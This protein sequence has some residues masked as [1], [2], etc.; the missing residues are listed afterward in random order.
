MTTQLA[1]P[2]PLR[3]LRWLLASSLAANALAAPNAS[4][5]K[6]LFS[7]C[8]VCHATAT[9]EKKVGPS[10]KGLF[11]HAKLKNG[12]SVSVPNVLKMIDTGGNGMPSYADIL[13]PQDKQDVIAYLR[14]L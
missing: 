1:S 14:T 7:Q 8:Q 4:N 10:L 11:K 5:G 13:S 12:R 6:A 3:P 2:R 9:P